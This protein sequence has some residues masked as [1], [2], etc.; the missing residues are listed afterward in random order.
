MKQ[1]WK[2]YYGKIWNII[3]LYNLML[4]ILTQ[5]DE[6]RQLWS[7]DIYQELHQN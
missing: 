7:I 2:V 3:V 6:M 4:L 5:Y 1:Y